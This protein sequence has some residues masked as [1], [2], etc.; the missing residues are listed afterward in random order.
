MKKIL[1]LLKGP[2]EEERSDLVY[3]KFLN[4]L[5]IVCI[6]F[7]E[8]HGLWSLWKG[9]SATYITIG[10]AFPHSL[11]QLFIYFNSIG[12]FFNI[13]HPIVGNMDILLCE[14]QKTQEKIE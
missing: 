3:N 11:F 8:K 4:Y 13:S 14:V 6:Y 1:R 12:I 10:S 2:T 9:C 7:I 5:I